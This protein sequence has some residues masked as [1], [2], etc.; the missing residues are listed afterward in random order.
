AACYNELKKKSE[1]YEGQEESFI[2]QQWLASNVRGQL[3]NRSLEVFY[4]NYD[5]IMAG[6]FNDSL[7]DASSAEQLVQILQSLSFT[8]IY[9]DK[10]IVESEIAG[11]EIISKLLE[12]F[13]P[14]VIYYDS[15]T[16]ERQT[17]KD[18]RLLTL[19]SDNY[20]GCYRKNAEGESETMKLYLRLLLVTDFICGM[21][22][23]YAK[24]LYQRLN[25]L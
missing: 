8:Y 21:T 22:D 6:T 10:G 23:S 19:I 2:V 14:A 9:Q 24:D 4:E 3:I 18:K 1:R 13:I 20:L 12:T 15:E 5:A 16:P 7:I 25:G 11:N 17:A